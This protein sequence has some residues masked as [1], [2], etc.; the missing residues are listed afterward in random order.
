M[1]LSVQPMT[2][3]PQAPAASLSQLELP[4][5]SGPLQLLESRGFADYRLLDCGNGRKLER[6]GRVVV[7]RPE[8]QAF[9]RPRLDAKA[10]NA[11]GSLRRR[12][13]QLVELFV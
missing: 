11:K 5:I 7:D 13:P 3:S 6:F 9:W 2:N 12:V 1:M 8:Q 4:V 10:W